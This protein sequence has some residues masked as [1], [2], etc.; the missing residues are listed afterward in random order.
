M[1]L[2]ILRR[3]REI[4]SSYLRDRV[5]QSHR[6]A[7]ADVGEEEIKGQR[8]KCVGHG[9]ELASKSGFS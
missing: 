6:E 4:P 7:V 9:V 8:R 1:P 3:R 2:R 5:A